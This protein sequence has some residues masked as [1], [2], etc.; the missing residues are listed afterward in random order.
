VNTNIVNVNSKSNPISKT[1]KVALTGVMAALI[2]VTTI[3][4]IPLPAPL[5]SINFA[6][7]VIFVVCVIFGPVIGASS[8]AIGCAIGYVAG[9]SLGTIGGGFQYIFLVGLVVARTP[10]ALSVGVLRKKS[11][12]I[13]MILG[14]TI[15]TFIF[16][17]IDFT[18][19]G[20]GYA[21]FDFGTFV[22][23]AFIPVALVIIVAVR[24]FLGTKYYT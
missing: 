18:L 13:G 5:A 15:E 11:Q 22:D 10:M 1:K 14:V 24:R 12:I 17:A 23:L 9:A 19:F 7:I 3:I 20:I 2:A 21:I 16:F 4:S 6:P 8:T